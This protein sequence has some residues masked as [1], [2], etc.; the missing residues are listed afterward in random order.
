MPHWPRQNA[1]ARA[2]WHR[3]GPVD[4]LARQVASVVERAGIL[5]VARAPQPGLHLDPLS[6]AELGRRFARA[7]VQL[8]AH[9]GARLQFQHE[10]FAVGEQRGRLHHA[11]LQ[12][13]DLAGPGFDFRRRAG[14][15]EQLYQPSA[16]QDGQPDREIEQAWGTGQAGNNGQRNQRADG[17]GQF[18]SLEPDE[19]PGGDPRG[20]ADRRHKQRMTQIPSGVLVAE[21]WS[22]LS[23]NLQRISR[24][25]TRS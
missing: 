20:Q 19:P 9:P 16:E 24:T 23:G 18:A 14:P 13:Q 17:E 11:A 6:V 10:L 4:L 3:S 15:L 2:G 8:R 21:T 22:R 25:S 7:R 5:E 1:D 12:D